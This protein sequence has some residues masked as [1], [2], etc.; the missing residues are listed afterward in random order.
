M[1]QRRKNRRFERR[2][3]HRFKWWENV[4]SAHMNVLPTLATLFR[5]TTT[6]LPLLGVLS[7]F[8]ISSTFVFKS[9][10]CLLMLTISASTEDFNWQVGDTAL[11]VR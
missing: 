4:L 5:D 9:R 1:K 8:K 7:R 6:L 11:A 2:F 10:T 3:L